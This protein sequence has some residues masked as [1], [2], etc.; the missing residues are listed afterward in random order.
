[1]EVQAQADRQTIEL[2]GKLE[3]AFTITA[4]RVSRLFFVLIQIMNV[5]SM[6]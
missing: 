4:Q 3:E 1:M 6:Y 2:V 5:N